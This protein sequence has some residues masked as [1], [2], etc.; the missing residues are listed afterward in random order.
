MGFVS[1]DCAFVMLSMSVIVADEL[2]TA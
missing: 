1:P 2:D